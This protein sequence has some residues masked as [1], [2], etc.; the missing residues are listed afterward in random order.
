MAEH[1]DLLLLSP[2]RLLREK[3]SPLF[4]EADY[5]CLFRKAAIIQRSNST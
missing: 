2:A 1:S 5:V 3:L 4:M